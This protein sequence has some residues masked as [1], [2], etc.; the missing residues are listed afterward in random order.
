M[1]SILRATTVAFAG[2]ALMPALAHAHSTADPSEGTAGGYLRTAFRVTHG[3]KGSATTAVTIRIPE[4][5]LSA[6]PMPKAGW[7][8]E[9]KTRPLDTPVDSGHGFKIR[10]AVTEVTWTGGR[11]ENAHFDEFVLS[12]RLPDKPGATLYFPMVQICEKGSNNWTGIPAAGQ[13]WGDLPEP[14]PYITVK[15]AVGHAH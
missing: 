12:M 4:G 1:L 6:K 10:E 7:T 8:I 13:K 5:V 11:L 14:A 2:L 3:C 15:K 9:T